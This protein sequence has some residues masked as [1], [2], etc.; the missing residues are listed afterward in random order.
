MGGF[1]HRDLYEEVEKVDSLQK[2]RMSEQAIEELK[3]QYRLFRKLQKDVLEVDVDYG[4]P[5]GKRSGKPSLYKSGAEKLTRLFQLVT[6][7]QIVKMIEEDD[8]IEYIFKCTLKTPDG[9]VVGEG[10]GACNSREKKHWNSNPWANQNTILKMAKKRAHVDATLTG[11]GASNVFT[12]DIEDY[13]QEDIE[14]PISEAQLRKIHVLIRDYARAVER[15][16]EEIKASI[17]QRH[18]IQHLNELTKTQAST[19]IKHL[20]DFLKERAKA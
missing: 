1:F 12:Q 17:K 10:Y 4:W 14:P 13:E 6:D 20:E 15:D 8:F 2:L 11:L 3:D 18:G 16:P 7:F 19:I 9:L 5:S